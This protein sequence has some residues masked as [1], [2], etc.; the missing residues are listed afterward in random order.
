MTI[1]N[2]LI[3]KTVEAVKALYSTEIAP[4]IIQLQAT[5]KEFD[6]DKTIVVFPFVKASKKNPELTA[7]ELGA[8]LL[9]NVEAVTAFN[10]IK[11]FLNLSISQDYWTSV[12]NSALADRQFGFVPV[13]PQSKTLM[14]EYSSPNTNKPLHLGHIRNNLLGFSIAQ[15]LS[16]NGYNVLKVNLVNDRGIHIWPP[17]LA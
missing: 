15:I 17:M 9:E 16:A 8:Y 3:S 1:E 13:T 12:L 2:I 4:E 5:R 11:G 6:G 14:V 10:V 7:N